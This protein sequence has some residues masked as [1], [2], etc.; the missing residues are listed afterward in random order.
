MRSILYDTGC[1]ILSISATMHDVT[2]G[3]RYFHNYFK[4]FTHEK[5]IHCE[6]KNIYFKRVITP[7][8]FY[9]QPKSAIYLQKVEKCY[10]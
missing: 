5:F 3:N 6:L 7:S 8:F 9:L 10:F 1:V 4:I 2:S